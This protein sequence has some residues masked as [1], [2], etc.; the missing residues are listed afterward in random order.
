MMVQ[1]LCIGLRLLPLFNSRD[2][3][4]ITNLCTI[5]HQTV[6][7]YQLDLDLLN[8]TR[9]RQFELSNITCIF[10]PA[11]RIFRR[12]ISTSFKEGGYWIELS[13]ER[14]SVLAEVCLY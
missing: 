8:P 14:T 7:L 13:S 4:S 11:V 12:Y 9:T 10:E 5:F 1:G 6:A 2:T 3:E